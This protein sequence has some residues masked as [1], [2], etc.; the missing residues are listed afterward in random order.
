MT[1][2]DVLETRQ[3]VAERMSQVTQGHSL[4]LCFGNGGC[5]RSLLD[6]TP[7][8][9]RLE[10]T[11]VEANLLAFLQRKVEGPLHHSHTF[12]V[13]VA[14][15]PNACSQVPIKDFGVIV[16]EKPA[17]HGDLC[18]GCGDCIKACREEAII[19]K[20]GRPSIIEERCLLCGDCRRACPLEAINARERGYLVLIGGKLGRHPQLAR[21]LLHMA[22]EDQVVTAL[23]LTL[24]FYK[25][26]S[27]K[28][29]R[30]GTVIQRTGWRELEKIFC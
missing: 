21:P 1:A 14:N 13:A 20:E 15:C 24:D 5:P 6:T 4:A 10:E 2:R 28:G 22:S 29:E 30:L 26:H 7:L 25:R 12:Q 18:N 9:E 11:L 23:E 17:I 16:Q 19:M 8:Q 27:Q 3:A